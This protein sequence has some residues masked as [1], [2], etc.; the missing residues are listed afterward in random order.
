MIVILRIKK[1]Q[2]TRLLALNCEA[3]RDASRGFL[4]VQSLTMAS[5]ILFAATSTLDLSEA[6]IACGRPQPVTYEPDPRADRLNAFF[7]A[8]NCPK[9]HHVQDYIRAADI[10]GLDYRLLPAISV[11]ETT[12]GLAERDNNRW[13]YHPGRRTFPSI[14]EGINFLARQLAEHPPY[15]GKSLRQKLFTY[16][17]RPSYPAEVERLMRQ[18]E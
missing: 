14:G 3:A 13:G 2:V 12:C 5:L 1:S 9:P 17:P 11:R 6:A 8:Y 10:Y 18:I 7:R 16:N 15:A 4:R